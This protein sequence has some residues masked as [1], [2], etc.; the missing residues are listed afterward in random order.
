MYNEIILFH[1]SSARA[2]CLLAHSMRSRI[3]LE[4]A[5]AQVALAHSLIA[6]YENEESTEI[7][8][9]IELRAA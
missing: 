7:Y 9:V 1:L 4:K 5:R 8:N 6:E 2:Y 3:Y